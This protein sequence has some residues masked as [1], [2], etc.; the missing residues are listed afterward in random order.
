MADARERCPIQ[1]A[2]DSIRNELDKHYFSRNSLS[3]VH[4]LLRVAFGLVILA[5]SADGALLSARTFSL[6][7]P[8]D[9]VP[10]D[11]NDL[12]FR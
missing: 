5:G 8:V 7:G 10:L 11:S 4:P 2:D 6:I 12:P 1:Q 3:A 9:F